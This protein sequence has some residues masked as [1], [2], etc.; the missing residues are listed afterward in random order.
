MKSAI[1][2]DI[3]I[4]ILIDNNNEFVVQRQSLILQHLLVHVLL[5]SERLL[6][7]LCLN[8]KDFFINYLNETER[9]REKECR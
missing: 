1:R 8:N 7:V 2:I 9:E 6:L 5:P 4:D 3:D